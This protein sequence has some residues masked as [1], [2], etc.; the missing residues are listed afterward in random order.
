MIPLRIRGRGMPQELE[1][2]A[3]LMGTE[4][5]TRTASYIDLE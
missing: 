1:E 3:V 5:G 2:S 4:T